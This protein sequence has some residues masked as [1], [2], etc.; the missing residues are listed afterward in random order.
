M[1]FQT[2]GMKRRCEQRKRS[3]ISLIEV[4]AVIVIIFIVSASIQIV[5]NGRPM[6][7]PLHKRGPAT[8][9]LRRDCHAPENVIHPFDAMLHQ[10]ATNIFAAP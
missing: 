7:K 3:G 5:S 2:G 9:E 1:R 10:H 6:P 8:N 4:I